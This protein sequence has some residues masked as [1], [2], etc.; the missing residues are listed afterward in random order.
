MSLSTNINLEDSKPEVLLQKLIR[1]KTIN[2][3]GN[4][5]DCIKFVYNLLKE[6]GLE[7]V[8]LC[9]KPERLNLVAR[10][11]GQGTKPP[12]LMYGHVDVVTTEYQDWEYPPF[13]GILA[14]ECIWGRGALDMKGALSMMICAI[15][16]AKEENFVPQGDVI[17]CL[18]SD[19]EDGGEYGAKYI[20]EN[21]KDLFDGVKYAIG[22]IGGFT[23][24]IGGKRFYPIM[25]SEK[26]R[27]GIKVVIKGEGG[28]GSLPMRDGAM[29]KIGNIINTLNKKR[30]PVHI[31][32]PVKMMIE[33]LASNMSFAPGMAMKALLKPAMTD[34]LLTRMGHQGRI[35]DSVLHNTVNATIVQGG[36][37]I[38][39]IPSEIEL[40]FDVRMLPGVQLEEL[41][42]E[43]QTLVG[44]DVKLE[45]LFYDKG[46]EKID[47]GLFNTLAQII[48]EEDHEGIPIPFVVSGVTDARFFSKLG[49]QTYGFTP[50]ILP[51]GID[52]SKLIHNSNERIPVN[53]LRFGA[54]SIYKLITR[55]EV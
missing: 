30:L 46:P 38:N 3:P 18:V 16:R 51:E 35:F 9:D 7:V 49:I 22:E 42:E 2:P 26:Q 50:M 45:V 23:M 13:E 21:H 14:D 20:V 44:N 40:S 53:A 31:T 6:A 8:L 37:K 32:P 41:L 52:F 15:L 33:A 29:A 4:E 1:F 36:N 10:L 28:H 25:V 34:F 12:L 48:K 17:L 43:L 47:L 39:V 27:C 54:E 5:A 24:R 11:K 19:E 55:F